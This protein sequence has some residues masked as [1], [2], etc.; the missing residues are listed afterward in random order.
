MIRC[1]PG[2]FERVNVIGEQDTVGRQRE[3]VD[4]AF[5]RQQA[6]ESGK[7]PPQQRLAAGEPH[8]VDAERDEDVDQRTDFLEMQQILARQPDVLVLRHAV[9]A[10]DIAPVGDR[11]PQI[12]ERTIERVL[13]EHRM[14]I[15]AR[16]AAGWL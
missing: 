15:S 2:V 5:R 10:A 1:K 6:H 12:A 4:A 3:I 16:G 11:Q 7:V 8:L 13:Q 14:I 9:L